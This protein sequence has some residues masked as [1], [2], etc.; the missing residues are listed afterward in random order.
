MRTFR[1]ARRP[2]AAAALAG[3]ALLGGT[4]ACGSPAPAG[5]NAPATSTAA[6]GTA[7]A[8]AASPSAASQTLASLTADEI[9]RRA[10]A[11]LKTASSVHVTGSATSSGQSIAVNLTLGTKGCTGTLGVKGEGSFRLLKIGKKL[12]IRPDSKFWK[13]AVG[14]AGSAILPLVSG[15]YIEPGGKSSSL[16]PI[17]AFCSPS[18]FAG[19]FNSGEMVGLSKGATTTISGQ[20]ALQI[21]DTGDTA[22][23]YVTVSAHPQLLRLDAGRAVRFDFTRY[24]VPLHLTPPPASETID[25]AKYG[26]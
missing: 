1:Y 11:D 17:G 3:A 22:S 6:S 9:A 5:A 16:K 8:S 24:G 12:W 26:F 21:K 13:Y 2:A 25:G 20:P 14:S 19:F 18:Q 7:A 4:A 10:T 23:V 15:K